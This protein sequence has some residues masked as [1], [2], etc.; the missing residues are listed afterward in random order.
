MSKYV[1]TKKCPK[2][3]HLSYPHYDEKANITKWR[4]TY[5]KCKHT[6]KNEGK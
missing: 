4:C 1:P 2:C 6:W 5:T 3:Q